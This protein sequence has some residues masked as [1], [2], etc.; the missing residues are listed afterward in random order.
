MDYMQPAAPGWG[1]PFPGGSYG[2]PCETSSFLQAGSCRGDYP[3]RATRQ[4]VRKAEAV[5]AHR[6]TG[7]DLGN[8]LMAALPNATYIGF[9]GTPIDR[10]GYGK[11]TFKVFGSDDPETC[12]LDRY[13]IRESIADG[14]TVP[15]HY[16]LA[17]NDLQAYGLLG[18]LLS[19]GTQAHT[20]AQLCRALDPFQ[21]HS[22]RLQ[23]ARSF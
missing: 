23:N 9:T 15:L 3:Y 14:A 16:S 18:Q 6:T 5:H 12:Y 8:Y 19:S 10:S 7:G 1:G 22:M 11:G 13:S 4:H 17:P 21:R 20:E 2:L